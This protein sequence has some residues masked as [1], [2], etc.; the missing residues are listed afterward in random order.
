MPTS[1]TYA[2]SRF[3]LATAYWLKPPRAK[4]LPFLVARI[5]RDRLDPPAPIPDIDRIQDRP[6]GLAGLT[7]DMSTPTVLAAFGR[8]FYPLAHWGRMK[9]WSPPERALMRLKD[10]HIA[11][12]FRR[13]MRQTDF[14]VRFDTNFAGVLEGCAAPRKHSRLHLTWLTPEAQELHLRLH[15][16]GYGHSVE[17]YDSTGRL[18]GGVFG[19]AVG[20]VF[21]ALSMFHTTDNASKLAIVSL[22]HHLEQAGFSAVDHQIMS[23][24]VR[25]LGGIEIPRAEY[26]AYLE[27]QP[28]PALGPGRWSAKFTLQQTADWRPAGKATTSE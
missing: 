11:K 25:D 10:V 14:E 27:T 8:G 7:T 12:R 20:S 3:A 24:W 13:T 22:Y 5:I 6:P 1:G 26:K 4:W 18:V 16:E 28:A 9:W 17:I 21:S 19:V 2:L 15:E 23:P